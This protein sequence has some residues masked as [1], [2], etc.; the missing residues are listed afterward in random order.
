MINLQNKIENKIKEAKK[1]N[2]IKQNENRASLIIKLLYDELIELTNF[3]SIKEI[4]EELNSNFGLNIKQNSFQRALYRA[5]KN[6][7]KKDGGVREKPKEKIRVETISNLKEESSKIEDDSTDW[8]NNLSK[9]YHVKLSAHFINSVKKTGITEK[10][11]N[12][13]NLDLIDQAKALSEVIKFTSTSKT[14]GKNL[15]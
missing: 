4:N 3:K 13:L 2:L 8:I 10:E 14:L 15:Y 11:F 5:T 9:K 6:H 7:S 12:E 1:A